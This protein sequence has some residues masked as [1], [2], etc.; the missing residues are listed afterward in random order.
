LDDLVLSAAVVGGLITLFILMVAL[1]LLRRYLLTRPV[2]AFDCSL[3]KDRPVPGGW[4]LGV[5]RYEP[6][7]L[8]W[9]KVFGFSPRPGRTLARA[10]LVVLET[11][12]AK[13]GEGL[14]RR[15]AG[16]RHERTGLQRLRRVARI[17]PTSPT[18]VLP[19]DHGPRRRSPRLVHTVNS[20]HR[21]E[22]F[23]KGPGS[24]E[25][26]PRTSNPGRWASMPAAVLNGPSHRDPPHPSRGWPTRDAH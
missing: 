5:A 22:A 2:G 19:V 14:R 23:D 12:K 16:V 9:F 18:A 24:T 26:K 10:R 8:D 4:M 17:G 11:R 15:R 21:P 1:F 13:R 25:P 6:D 20:R 7:R 3:R